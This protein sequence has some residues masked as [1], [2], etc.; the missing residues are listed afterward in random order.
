VVRLPR[1]AAPAGTA[2]APGGEKAADPR[3]ARAFDA[4]R[5]VLVV[6]DNA[7]AREALRLL[8]EDEGHEV[9]SAGDGPSA[10]ESA[11][12]FPPEVVLLD[13][14]L[15][16]MD[17]YEV[18]RALR[19]IPGCERALIVAVSG[20]GQAEDRERSRIAGFDQHLL[21]PVAPERLLEI[22]RRPVPKASSL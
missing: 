13:I 17:G 1:A 2:A 3:A 4:G 7:D 18:A 9:R 21:K 11:A 6:D 8:L 14:G 20:Y 12:S 5:R 19:S 15:P 10:L 22:V 16:G